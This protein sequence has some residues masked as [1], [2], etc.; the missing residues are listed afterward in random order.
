MDD[1]TEDLLAS[2]SN[3]KNCFLQDALRETLEGGKNHF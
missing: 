3:N 1:N 2:A